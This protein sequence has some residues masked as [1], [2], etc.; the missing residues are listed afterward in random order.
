MIVFTSIEKISSPSTLAATIGIAPNSKL[1]FYRDHHE[2]SAQPAC[3]K[4]VVRCAKSRASYLRR[5]FSNPRP[6]THD[7]LLTSL[8]FV[9]M[10]PVVADASY[11]HQATLP[12]SC[13][14]ARLGGCSGTAQLSAWYDSSLP[15]SSS[16]RTS[17][18]HPAGV[19]HALD[20]VENHE[21]A[22][23][24]SVPG[25][26]ELWAEFL[27]CAM[28]L[29]GVGRQTARRKGEGK[30]GEEKLGERRTGGESELSFDESA[31]KHKGTSSSEEMEDYSPACPRHERGVGCGHMPRSIWRERP[32]QSQ[33]R[34]ERGHRN[35]TWVG[36]QCSQI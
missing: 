33:N 5:R 29:D 14:D 2:G 15:F 13:Y 11:I 31:E 36:N 17:S 8:K 28:P 26:A 25:I 21:A 3:T 7:G 9:A 1:L 30:D 4:M 19:Q 34:T 12:D 24:L 32:G 16:R 10:R 35:Q 6:Y 23:G 27:H 20:L 22:A 18:A